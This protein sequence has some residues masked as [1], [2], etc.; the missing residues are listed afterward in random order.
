MNGCKSSIQETHLNIEDS[1]NIRVT[2]QEK[3]FQVTGPKKQACV[4]IL[5][6]DNIEFK[7]KLIR[8]DRVGHSI[9]IKGKI[10]QD[11]EIPNIYEP[12]T[13][14]AHKKTLLHLKS[15][16]NPHT[17]IVPCSQQYTGHSEKCWS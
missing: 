10:H 1:H 16:V 2:G 13:R 14:F 15:H 9:F 3:I 5:I 17:L 11:H 8:R 6:S 12:N 4:V 7:P